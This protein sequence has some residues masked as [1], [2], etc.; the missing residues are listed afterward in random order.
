[1]PSNE[2]GKPSNRTF[3]DCGSYLYEDKSVAEGL[4]STSL[5]CET[6]SEL[7]QV[8][9]AW[10]KDHLEMKLRLDKAE[11]T[12]RTIRITGKALTDMVDDHFDDG[13]TNY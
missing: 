3:F 5:L 11:D 6:R 9:D 13:P 8:R 2:E 1:M 10:N 4:R 12:L 7:N